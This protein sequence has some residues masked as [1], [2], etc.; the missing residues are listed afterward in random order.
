MVKIS[1][2]FKIDKGNI[3]EKS[4]FQENVEEYSSQKTFLYSDELNN[5]TLSVKTRNCLL[6]CNISTVGELVEKNLKYLSREKNIGNSCLP[7][8]VK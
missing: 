4:N 2:F 5:T 1:K 6:R 8:K 7:D 3:S